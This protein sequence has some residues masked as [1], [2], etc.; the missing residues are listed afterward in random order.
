[1]A[2]NEKG[3]EIVSN[4]PVAAP[5]GFR[6]PPSLSEQIK[7]LVRIELS[8]AAEAAGQESFEE[9]DDF[10]IGD[11]Y[12][13]K[14]PYEQNFDH[15][16]NIA[17]LR[18]AINRGKEARKKLREIETVNKVEAVKPQPSAPKADDKA[19]AQ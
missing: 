5:V 14:S 11:D 7:R 6:R 2:L 12:D 19:V 10:D 15:D 13:P 1:M 18:D 3:E 16:R 8:A 4:V 17:E 9:A